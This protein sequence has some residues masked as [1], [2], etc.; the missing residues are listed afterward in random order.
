MKI[1]QLSRET[2]VAV[3]L[4]RYYESQGLLAS[5][6]TD[7]G[8]RVYS[9]EAPATVARIRR[10]LAAGFP[11]RTIRELMP[12][13]E[14]DALQ[15]CVHHHLTDHLAG[16]EARMADLDKART[17]VTSLIASGSPLTTGGS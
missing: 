9:P 12:C 13:F 11:T 10:L 8:H 1:G 7:G 15:P 5:E 4:L 6:R 2:G 16:L 14:G 17:S 3:R